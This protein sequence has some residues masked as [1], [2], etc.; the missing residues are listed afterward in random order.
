MSRAERELAAFGG[1][2]LRSTVLIAPHHGSR[3]SSSDLFLA[4]VKPEYAIFTS[5]WKNRFKFPHPSVLDRYRKYGIRILRTDIDGAV[6][7]STDGTFLNIE[8]VMG[9]TEMDH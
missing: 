9:N 2:R 1:E 4:N 5:G 8:T 3:T 7:L 6:M